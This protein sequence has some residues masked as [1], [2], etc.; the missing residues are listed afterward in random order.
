MKVLVTGSSG[1]IGSHVKKRLEKE[2]HEVVGY[3]IKEGYDVR[4]AESL[5]KA[6][7]GCRSVVHLAALCIGQESLDNPEPYFATNSYGTF[8]ALNAAR[9]VG[10]ESFAYAASA[11]SVEALTPYGQSKLDGQLW[12]QLF[13]KLYGMNTFAL[14]LYNVY[15]E[16]DDKGVIDKWMRK[17]K[18]RNPIIIYGDGNQTRDFI[19]V[20][21]VAGAFADFA[22][23]WKSHPVKDAY[24]IGTGNVINVND[25]ARL[26]F[27]V[28]GKEA[29]IQ[30]FPARAGEVRHSKSENPYITPKITLE[31]G[32]RRLAKFYA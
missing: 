2:G 32:I 27:R 3:D 4:D 12:V 23:N 22:V 21:D 28:L 24:E 13:R 14:R 31:E 19:N 9:G 6:M 25:L 20:S 29:E 30:R 8:N 15:G 18:S 16:G 26:M 5:R 10:V 7:K 1:F 17:I 11:A